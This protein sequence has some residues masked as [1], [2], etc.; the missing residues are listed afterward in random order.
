LFVFDVYN[1][2][3][4]KYLSPSERHDIMV[5]L[6]NR[7]LNRDMV[8][9]VPVMA[10]AVSLDELG[11]NNTNELLAFA[12]G[13]SLNHPIREGLVFKRVDGGFSFKAISNAFLLKEKD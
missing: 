12:E 3:E 10:I 9:H 6:W 4:G 11:I 5:E 8:Q 2:D 13:P 7:G 1:I